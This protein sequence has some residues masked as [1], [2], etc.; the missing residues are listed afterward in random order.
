MGKDFPRS[1]SV[2]QFVSVLAIDGFYENIF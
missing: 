2:Y 1:N